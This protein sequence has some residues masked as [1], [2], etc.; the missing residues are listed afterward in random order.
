MGVRFSQGDF[1][2][3]TGVEL[4]KETSLDKF[5]LPLYRR[6]NDRDFFLHGD[7][8]ELV[9]GAVTGSSTCEVFDRAYLLVS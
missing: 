5:S 9:T 3:S 1:L 4:K 7:E 2:F 8:D 6:S